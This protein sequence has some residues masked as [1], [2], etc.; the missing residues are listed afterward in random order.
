MLVKKAGTILLNLE[1]QQIGLV[2]R[3]KDKSYTFPKGHL[4]KGESLQEC[5]IRETEE[6]TLRA[7]HLLINKEITILKYTTPL[8]EDVEN[9]MYIAVDDGPSSKDI[10]MCDREI[11]EWIEYNDVENKLVFSNLKLLWN[12]I[13]EPIYELLENNGQLNSSILESLSINS[14]ILVPTLYILTGPAGVGKST[15]SKEL[16]KINS[17]SVLIEG[18]DIYH[19]VVGGYVPAWKAGNHLDVFWDICFNIFQTY[20]SYG[21]SVI[22]NYIVTPNI[23]NRI[24]STFKDCKIKFIILLADEDTLLLRDSQRPKDCQMK[25][26]CITLLNNFKNK[27]YSNNNILNTTNLSVMETTDIINKEDRFLI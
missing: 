7:N 9:Y 13:K 6:E 21:Y 19:Q 22:F 2:Y 17:K 1:T 8:G 20:M 15:I 25:K 11:F 14:D 5:A 16:A 18:D 12:Q 27:E 10:P 3:K 23:V 24:K 4:E 26:R